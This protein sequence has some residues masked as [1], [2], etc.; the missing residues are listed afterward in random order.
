MRLLCMFILLFA[1]SCGAPKDKSSSD[2]KTTEQKV[3]ETIKE[4]KNEIIAV[5]KNPK[6]INDVK[7]LIKNSGLK[8][9]PMA[10]DDESSKIA[11]IEIPD[12]KFDF[13]IERLNNSRE[14]RTVKINSIAT[15]KE[16]IEREKN[17]LISLRKTKCFGDC[18]SYTIY[19]AKD[20]NASYEGKEFVL[21]KG[22]K[23]FK[24]SEKE[25]NHIN[26]LLTKKDFSSF[27][28]VYDNP[29]IMDLPSTFVVHNGKQIQIRLWNDDVP[30]V[31]MELNEYIE[32]ILLEK[33][34]FE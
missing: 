10:M 9:K 15:T 33:K 32:G 20:G 2:Q 17:N 18:P 28:D 26:A 5:L 11:V 34:F 19:I 7:A 8:W 13:W 29:R 22:T 16:L 1:F 3:K 12:G 30:E 25:L 21:E 31:L 27:K 14:F 6:S 24:L 23:E 4:P